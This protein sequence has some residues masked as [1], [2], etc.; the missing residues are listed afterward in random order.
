MN[1]PD[2]S[3]EQKKRMPWVEPEIRQLD[4]RETASNEGFGGDGQ[5]R[6]ADCTRS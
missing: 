6:F 5:K 2:M 3:V 1:K 4:V